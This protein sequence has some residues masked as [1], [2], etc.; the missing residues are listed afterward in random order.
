MTEHM[1]LAGESVHYIKAGRCAACGKTPVELK[2][3]GVK[4]EWVTYEDL[5]VPEDPMP[6]A[7]LD[8]LLSI[9]AFNDKPIENVLALIAGPLVSVL[10]GNI[11]EPNAVIELSK[12]GHQAATKIRALEDAVERN[13]GDYQAEREQNDAFNRAQSERISVRDRTI[14]SQEQEIRELRSGQIE[15]VFQV[16]PNRPAESI[17]AEVDIRRLVKELLKEEKSGKKPKK[18]KGKKKR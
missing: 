1:T 2:I 7:L 16:I 4:P 12:I 13:L 6:T 14:S 8:E 17:A 3:E 5:I 9:E 11:T 10:Y 15:Q 18:G